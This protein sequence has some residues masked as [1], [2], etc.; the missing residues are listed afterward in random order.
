M[1]YRDQKT[2]LRSLTGLA[3]VQG[4]YFTAKQAE[5]SGY[6]YPHLAYHLKAGNFERAGHGLYRIPTLPLS[7][8]DDLVRLSLWSR[9]RND[10]PQAVASHQTALGLHEL[11]ELIPSEI[12][13]TVPP[14]FRKRAPRGCILHKAKLANE[15]SRGMSGFRVTTP[16][17]T[18]QDLARDR[19]ISTEQFEKA[20]RD[21]VQRGLIRRSHAKPLLSGR[22]TRKIARTSKAAR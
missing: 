8:H 17:Q 20:V 13:L 2:A 18:L 7:E 9:D 12:H 21:A 6:A 4:G 11:G 16:L 22:K 15:A 19:S 5:E 1:T 14:A 10:L 3:A